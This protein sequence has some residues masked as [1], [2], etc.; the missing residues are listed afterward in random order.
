MN[1]IIIIISLKVLS[2]IL[3]MLIA[4]TII[5]SLKIEM[6]ENGMN[7]MIVKLVNLMYRN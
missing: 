7:L 2:F 6:M 1:L 5:R 3:D 4:D